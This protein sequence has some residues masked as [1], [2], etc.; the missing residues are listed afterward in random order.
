MGYKNKINP[1]KIIDAQIVNH[2]NE[3]SKIGQSRHQA[4][5]IGEASPFIFSI[6]TY[7]NYKQTMFVFS[8]WCLKKHPEIKNIH[9]QKQFVS[10]YIETLIEN[11][12]SSYTQK[13]RLSAFRKFY[14]DR[15]DDIFTEGRKRSQIKRG[16]QDTS[17]ARH[18]SEQANKELIY[19]CQHTGLRRSELE[20]LK[21]ACVKKHEDGNYYIENIKGKGG[22][23]R[24]VR[25]LNNDQY[26]INKINETNKD[27]LVWGRV[28]SKANIHGYRADYCE[29]LYKSL[30]RDVS[31]LS[32]SNVYICR[33]DMAGIKL[34]KEAMKICSNNLGHSRIGII[35]YN[36]LY[37]LKNNIS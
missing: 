6:K 16:R 10:E 22:R 37:G 33:D 35:A 1:Q 7:E 20:N 11:S 14:D 4:K 29:A 31:K 15:F 25:I 9:D 36:Y 18:F 19:F 21:G 2:L 17:Q 5:K 24:D 3:I 34:D 13:S 23:I 27:E 28:H 26:V 12:Y 30:A 8:R 32:T